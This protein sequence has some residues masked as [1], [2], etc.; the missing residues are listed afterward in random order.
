[1]AGKTLRQQTLREHLKGQKT[2]LFFLQP[3][4]MVFSTLVIMHLYLAALKRSS[5][6][7]GFE[8]TDD[9]TINTREP[10]QTLVLILNH[11]RLLMLKELG[12]SSIVI[13]RVSHP[14]FS[15]YISYIFPSALH[16]KFF[17]TTSMGR[18]SYRLQEGCVCEPCCK[19]RARSNQYL[20]GWGVRSP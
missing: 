1:M 18:L 15:L 11:D 5:G 6:R 4:I 13:H 16:L 8:V 19:Q 9:E 10:Q 14:I 2:F 12:T 3:T 7:S 20:K 17:L